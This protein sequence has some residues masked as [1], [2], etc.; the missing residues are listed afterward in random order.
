MMENDSKFDEM[1]KG[2]IITM[3][4]TEQIAGTIFIKKG[5]HFLNASKFAVKFK[6]ITGYKKKTVMAIWSTLNKW[7]PLKIAVPE[8][9]PEPQPECEPVAESKTAE[10]GNNDDGKESESTVTEHPVHRLSDIPAVIQSST[11][12]AVSFGTALSVDDHNDDDIKSDEF[13]DGMNEIDENK[14]ESEAIIADPD[15][16]DEV[17]DDEECSLSFSECPHCLRIKAVLGRF[18]QIL[19]T[20]SDPLTIHKRPKDD[21]S[22]SERIESVPPKTVSFANDLD[23]NDI[24][25]NRNQEIL[26]LD[27]TKTAIDA[28]FESK[29]DEFE[30]D[31]MNS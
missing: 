19:S 25:M 28:L 22:D 7:D 26:D 14:I 10:T 16:L 5:D 9:L 20:P 4:T 6:A 2:A 31:L 8:T 29:G 17:G 12:P 24:A 18:G 27:S 3:I 21:D 30:V 15:A 13:E 1:D 11:S 23:P